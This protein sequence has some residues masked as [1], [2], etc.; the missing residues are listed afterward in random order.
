MYKYVCVY[1]YVKIIKIKYTIFF[2]TISSPFLGKP[3]H[4]SHLEDDVLGAVDLRQ[5]EDPFPQ[6]VLTG[7]P[8]VALWGLLW[9][10]GYLGWD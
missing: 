9:P 2:F 1:I 4:R 10:W 8:S 7:G 6:P 3:R 5:G